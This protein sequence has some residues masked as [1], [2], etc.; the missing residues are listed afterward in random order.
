MFGVL[1]VR[2]EYDVCIEEGNFHDVEEDSLP[3]LYC[4]NV[5]AYSI[6]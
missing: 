5:D 3:P 4:C 2:L 6:E 1:I